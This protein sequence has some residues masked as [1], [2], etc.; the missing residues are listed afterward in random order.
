[1]DKGRLARGSWRCLD[2]FK[3]NAKKRDVRA[4]SRVFAKPSCWVPHAALRG[5][6]P[7]HQK[8]AGGTKS[9][10]SSGHAWNRVGTADIRIYIQICI[11]TNVDTIARPERLSTH[12]WINDT[13]AYTLVSLRRNH[14]FSKSSRPR[15]P[16]SERVT[17][18]TSYLGSR[19]EFR[20]LHDM[21]RAVFE[22]PHRVPSY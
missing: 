5:C 8:P 10:A 3:W 7:T 14:G 4:G 11:S 1:M 17:T 6:S 16:A 21:D 20:H 18:G 19:Q 13:L 15:P 2:E 12:H 22:I 9:Q